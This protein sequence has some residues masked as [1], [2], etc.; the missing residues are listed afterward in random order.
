MARHGR[1][2]ALPQAVSLQGDARVPNECLSAV[3]EV[4]PCVVMGKAVQQLENGNQDSRRMP[5][6]HETY[7]SGNWHV[8]L[9]RL[10]RGPCSLIW[11]ILCISKSW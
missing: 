8:S 2:T 11:I 7:L 3:A 1:P 4:C 6:K 10:S 9:F 5:P